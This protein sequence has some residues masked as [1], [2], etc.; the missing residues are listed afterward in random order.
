MVSGR[1]HLHEWEKRGG[2]AGRGGDGGIF[3]GGEDAEE[4][5]LSSW[6]LA[7]DGKFPRLGRHLLAHVGV[8]GL[9]MS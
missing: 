9:V 4:S 7:D 1:V 3:T 5:E 2:G 8:A 6:F